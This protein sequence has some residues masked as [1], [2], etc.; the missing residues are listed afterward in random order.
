MAIRVPIRYITVFGVTALVGLAI[1]TYGPTPWIIGA[2]LDTDI[3]GG[4]ESERLMRAL[5]GSIAVL[6]AAL[7]DA[8]G[9]L[10][11]TVYGDS[12]N[13][14][15]RLEQLNKNSGTYL[16]ISENTAKLAGDVDG[17]CAVGKTSIRGQE[18]LMKTYTLATNN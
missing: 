11:Y 2:H 10:S 18:K 12:V 7:A 13:L 9:R 4:A 1:E 16:L 15:A 3:Y 5:L 8:A 6:L 17:L 14:A